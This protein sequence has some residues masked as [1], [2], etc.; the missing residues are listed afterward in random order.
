[1]AYIRKHPDRIEEAITEFT[2]KISELTMTSEDGHSRVHVETLEEWMRATN[3]S[4]KLNNTFVTNTE[5]LA[6]AAYC[7]NTPNYVKTDTLPFEPSSI[8][9]NDSTCCII[10]FSILLDLSL[11]HV[12]HSFT[13]AGVFDS[14]LP[15][16]LHQLNVML[17]T[18]DLEKDR[19][20]VAGRFYNRQWYLCPASF[21]NRMDERAWQFRSKEADR[22]GWTQNHFVLTSTD[23]DVLIAP[24]YLGK[25][26]LGFV[27]AY[28][29]RSIRFPALVMQASDHTCS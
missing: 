7:G 23:D 22:F 12:L 8:A 15:I 26:S 6:N 20:E 21:H 5:L 13:R 16:G 4:T 11:G 1:M 14:V 9:R 25:G 18:V 19:D 3:I 29:C 24:R 28:H 2:S 17:R 10:V 27:Q